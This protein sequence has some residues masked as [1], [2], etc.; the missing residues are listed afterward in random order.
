MFLS[1]EKEQNRY[2]GFIRI[3]SWCLVIVGLALVLF[4][5]IGSESAEAAYIFSILPPL[6]CRFILVRTDRSLKERIEIFLMIIQTSYRVY[7][8]NPA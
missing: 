5:L 3:L 8:S 7:Q 6:I 2:R 1:N 4:M